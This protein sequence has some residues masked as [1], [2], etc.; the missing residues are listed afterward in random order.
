ME[1]NMK[2]TKEYLDNKTEEL[3]GK[4]KSYIVEAIKE[5]KRYNNLSDK[6]MA[7]ALDISDAYYQDIM[8]NKYV[9]FDVN[10]LSSIVILSCG[11]INFGNVLNPDIEF[12][13]E[14]VKNYFQELNQASR[15]KKIKE[16]LELMDI[17][18]NTLEGIDE[19]IEKL[20]YFSENGKKE[21]D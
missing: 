5:I 2:L 20:K 11:G 17:N 1:L 7:K 15:K 16:L 19:Y 9:C 3:T 21:E 8:S 6:E 13:T 12:T 10:L 18:Y 4:L 14:D